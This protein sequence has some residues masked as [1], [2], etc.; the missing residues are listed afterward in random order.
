MPAGGMEAGHHGLG[1]RI[2]RHFVDALGQAFAPLAAVLSEQ[3]FHG[4]ALDGVAAVMAVTN[5]VRAFDRGESHVVANRTLSLAI[6]NLI[7][8]L[9]QKRSRRN[10]A[11]T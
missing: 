7:D 10:P 2:H 1:E 9:L 11:T 5:A 4:I 3:L 6:V 8:P